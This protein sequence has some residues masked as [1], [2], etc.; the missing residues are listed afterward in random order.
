[1]RIG[2]CGIACEKCPRMQKGSCPNGTA[3]CVARENNF[4]Q[5]CNCAPPKALNSALNAKSSPVKPPSKD[6]S[7]MVTAS[8]FLANP[9]IVSFKF[10]V[11]NL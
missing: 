1:M 10:A 5:I 6:P 3:G 7:A 9:K 2:V 4:C 11:V 8:T